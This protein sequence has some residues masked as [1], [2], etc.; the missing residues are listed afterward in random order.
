VE[1]NV[2]WEALRARRLP[3]REAPI[4]LGVQNSTLKIPKKFIHKKII[5]FLVSVTDLF[6]HWLWH[7]DGGG[8]LEEPVESAVETSPV[9]KTVARVRQ[10]P[11]N[12]SFLG[13]R[14]VA[15]DFLPLLRALSFKHARAHGL[16]L[17][18]PEVLAAN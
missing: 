16:H 2:V 7:G 8:E 14:F 17:F 11:R 5:I 4:K 1:F 18:F 6:A 9:A 12:Q 10:T 3:H 13:H 15:V